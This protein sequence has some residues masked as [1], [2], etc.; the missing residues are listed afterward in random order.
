MPAFYFKL[1]RT[2]LDRKVFLG[3]NHLAHFWPAPN[4]KQDVTFEH[5]QQ[6]HAQSNAIAT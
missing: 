2:Y 1:F 5:S 4:Y 6:H 3:S